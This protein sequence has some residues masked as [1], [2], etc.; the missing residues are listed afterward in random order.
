MWKKGA[1]RVWCKRL[2]D[3]I[4]LILGLAS[5][6]QDTILQRDISPAVWEQ[7]RNAVRKIYS[8][9]AWISEKVEPLLGGNVIGEIER[10]LDAWADYNEERH[11]DAYYLAGKERP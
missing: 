4:G 7:V 2:R 10:S 6:D 8:Y 3:A 1:V 9:D 5:S 11:L